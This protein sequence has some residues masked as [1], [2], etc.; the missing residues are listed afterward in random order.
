MVSDLVRQFAT[1]LEDIIALLLGGIP[2]FLHGVIRFTRSGRFYQL[3]RIALPHLAFMCRTPEMFS[4]VRLALLLLALLEW[5][6]TR[7]GRADPYC[8]MPGIH[9]FLLSC[10]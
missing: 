4:S 7:T 3:L 1:S 9:S 5:A 6:D 10:N 8:S 2:P